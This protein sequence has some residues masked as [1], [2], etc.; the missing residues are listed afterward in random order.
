MNKLI[1]IIVTALT[2]TFLGSFLLRS[3]QSEAG[4]YFLIGF[5]ILIGIGYIVKLK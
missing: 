5:C 1:W 3:F 4:V 2:G